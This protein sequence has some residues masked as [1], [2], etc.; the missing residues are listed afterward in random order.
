M[1]CE[2]GRGR[3]H[4]ELE[5]EPELEPTHTQIHLAPTRPIAGVGTYGLG[6]NCHF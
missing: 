5:P 4:L 2:I 6:Y 1:G 3:V